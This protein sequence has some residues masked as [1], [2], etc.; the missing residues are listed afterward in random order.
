[1]SDKFKTVSTLFSNLINRNAFSNIKNQWGLIKVLRPFLKAKLITFSP[2]TIYFYPYI[3]RTFNIN[4]RY[5]T[6][7]HHYSFLQNN[8]T[9]AQLE[10]LFTNGMECFKAVYG[11]AEFSIILKQNYTSEYEGPLSLYFKVNDDLISTLSFT[12]MPGDI[13]NEGAENLIYISHLQRAQTQQHNNEHFINFFRNIHPSVVLLRAVEALGLAWGISKCVAI[14]AENQLSYIAGMDKIAFAHTYDEFWKGRGGVYL[15]C[16][17]HFQLPL[18][19]VP[20][21]AIKQSHR[22]K[23]IRRRNRLNEVYTICYYNFCRLK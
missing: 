17:Y 11:D 13:L 10:Q 5:K 21:P 2:Y 23:T 3:S 4:D 8:Y 7:I 16:A 15:N 14:T 20:L 9:P 22:N 12:F 19:E 18:L 6:L 1:M